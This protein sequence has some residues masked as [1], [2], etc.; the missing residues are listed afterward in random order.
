LKRPTQAE[1]AREYLA[2]LELF[3]I[4][5]GL[6][7][8]STLC[9][10]LGEPQTAFPS[11][12]IGGTNGKGSVA[13]F[14]DEA[15]RAAGHRVGRY[16]SPHLVRL[17]ERFHIDGVPVPAATLDDAID[18]VRVIGMDLA[19][20]GTL[21]AYPTF[22]EVTTAAAFLLFQ[23]AKVDVA[24][25]EVGL[26]G[27][28][29]AT[30]IVTPVAAAITSIALDHERHLGSTIEA[31]AGEKAGIVKTGVPL[32]VGELPPQARKI[33]GDVCRDR[34][35][36]IIDAI[37]DCILAATTESGRTTM[38]LA[39]PAGDYGA[40]RLSL[41][42]GHQIHNAVTAVRL[43]ESA[44]SHGIPVSPAAVRAGLEQAVWP[45]RLDLRCT[46]DGRCVLIDG[47]HNPAGAAALASYI[48]SE[49]PEGR[50]L[51]F[52]AMQ[53]KDLAGMLAALSPVSNPL[54]LTRAP[55]RRAACTRDLALAARQSG[56]MTVVVEPNIDRALER[57][58]SCHPTIVAA[59]SLYLAGAVLA[60]IER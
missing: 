13:A 16:T 19:A 55:G 26:G 21:D 34:Q 18:R 29:D 37:D 45:G 4:K 2:S 24:V 54:V 42:G 40:V 41:R 57:A 53:D 9:R 30:N 10:A 48:R 3:G 1:T 22:F 31:I 28:F 60:R 11:L 59:G 52:G 8:V 20:I 17:E 7:N 14:A 23:D 46:D 39:T 5:L 36:P 35:A 32:V 33:I 38:A 25:L 44:D 12:L 47:A 6:S 43:L 49:W 51:V 50:P 58:W 15:L 27:R 56:A